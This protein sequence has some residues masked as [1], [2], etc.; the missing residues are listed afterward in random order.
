MYINPQ[1]SIIIPNYNHALFLKQRIN[2]VLNQTFQDFE[3]I[4]LD[5]GSIDISKDI[6]EQYRN[7]PKVSRIVYNRQN[8][9]GVFKQWIKGIEMAKGVYVWIAESDDYA[10][11]T[12]LE[13]TVGVLE[14]DN[15]AGM[16]FTGNQTVASN[17]EFLRNTAEYE[18]ELYNQLL[19]FQ[20]T[21]N[22]VNVAQFFISDMIIEN[23]SSVLFRKEDLLKID[24]TE[25]AK[26]ITTG[27]R[28]VYN[29]IAL[30]TKIVYLPEVLNYMRSHEHNTTKKSFGNGNIH[31]D[32]LQVLNYYFNKMYISSANRKNIVAFYKT[33]Y[34]SFIHF[35][36]YKNNLEVLKK[37]KEKKEINNSFYHAVSFNL[38]LFKKC[39]IKSRF[40]RS[41]YYR[42]LL[43]QK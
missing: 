22:K 21:I 43:L 2:S 38:Y 19:H 27:D 25:L 14:K 7:H 3:I 36:D 15:S 28:F 10:A 32:R 39:N 13:Q 23:A 11:P 16:V 40:L 31:K 20:N 9:G 30:Q 4:I 35:G 5:D 17:G 8:S 37:L 41:V 18:T 6:I 24:F 42:I 29:G 34:L 12:F 33:N 26:F 1:V